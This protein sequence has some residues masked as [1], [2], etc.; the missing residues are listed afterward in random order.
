MDN[1][2]HIVVG[3]VVRDNGQGGTELRPEVLGVFLTEAEA[4]NYYEDLEFDEE[5][6]SVFDADIVS[7][8]INFGATEEVRIFLTEEG[9]PR[10]VACGIFP[11]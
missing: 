5:L 8:T 7:S 11:K 6:N 10:S 4:K 3:S 2:L 1:N 9:N